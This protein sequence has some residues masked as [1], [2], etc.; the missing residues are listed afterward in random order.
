VQLACYAHAR[1]ASAAAFVTLDGDKVLAVAP[2]HDIGEL[3][4]LNI[5]RLATVFGQMR[6]GA[7]LPANGI[8]AVCAYC[9]M[10]GLCR[11]GEWESAHG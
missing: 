2:P 1:A 10:Q 5:M 6:A 9:E 4:Q 8:D 7:A 3:A 11:K